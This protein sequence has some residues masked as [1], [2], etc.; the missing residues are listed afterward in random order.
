MATKHARHRE[1]AVWFLAEAL[2]AVRKP[3]T[4]TQPQTPTEEPH[5]PH[6]TIAE[7]SMISVHVTLG[8]LSRLPAQEKMTP[9][10]GNVACASA[11]SSTSPCPGKTF[12]WLAVFVSMLAGTAHGFL[13]A[14]ATGGVID[15]RTGERGQGRSCCPTSGRIALSVSPGLGCLLFEKQ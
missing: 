12:R 1:P 11:L 13:L 4:V 8:G 6:R 9:S 10:R 2:P 7:P 3:R 15:I 14:P 5:T